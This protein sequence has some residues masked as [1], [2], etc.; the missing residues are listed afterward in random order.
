MF[1]STNVVLMILCLPM[2]PLFDSV[3]SQIPAYDAT[4][5]SQIFMLGSKSEF[6]II[7]KYHIIRVLSLHYKY[8]NVYIT[9]IPFT[10][11]VCLDSLDNAL[12]N[13]CRNPC[14]SFVN[15]MFELSGA[16]NV[17]V[18]IWSVA[19]Q[20]LVSTE[21]QYFSAGRKMLSCNTSG[22]PAGV[23]LCSIRTDG[24]TTT[25]KLLIVK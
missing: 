20:P 13:N 8:T 4:F 6:D 3:C 2:I 10:A 19:G 17:S 22:L 23:Y 12:I 16:G 11:P 21:E 25:R 15:C 14:S 7:F 24:Y 9:N 1:L 5:Y 18:I